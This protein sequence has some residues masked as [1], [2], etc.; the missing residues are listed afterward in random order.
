ML[1]VVLVVVV[2]G[3]V[4]GDR[5]RGERYNIRIPDLRYQDYRKMCP[6]VDRLID[7]V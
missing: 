2:V 4:S 5:T 6:N 7:E 3:V 1:L